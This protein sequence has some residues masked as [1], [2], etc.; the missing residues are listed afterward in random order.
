[1]NFFDPIIESKCLDRLD[2]FPLYK[3]TACALDLVCTLLTYMFKICFSMKCPY[4]DKISFLGG[5]GGGGST[6]TP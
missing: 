5:E 1:M 2:I 3:A 4:L 6:E